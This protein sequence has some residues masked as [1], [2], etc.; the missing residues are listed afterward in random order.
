LW[1]WVFYIVF[2]H[3]LF[4][5]KAHWKK[6]WMGTVY[7]DEEALALEQFNEMVNRR[8]KAAHEEVKKSVSD[9][10][11]QASHVLST[12]LAPSSEAEVKPQE[13]GEEVKAPAEPQDP[14]PTGESPP[15]ESGHH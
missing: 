6:P 15:P 12:T 13:G 9:S 10:V 3:E 4:Q 2:G 14:K 7:K 1:M 8:L 5:H 11:A